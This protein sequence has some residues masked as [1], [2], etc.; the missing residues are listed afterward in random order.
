V[1][2]LRHRA[3]YQVGRRANSEHNDGPILMITIHELGNPVVFKSYQTMKSQHVL[4]S[5]CNTTKRATRCLGEL[6]MG[7]LHQ[8]TTPTITTG[9]ANHRGH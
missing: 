8:A 3:V 2:T 1:V 6:V 4:R 9:S 5:T 7:L